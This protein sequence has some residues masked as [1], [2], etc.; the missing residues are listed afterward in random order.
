M[1]KYGA[2]LLLFLSLPAPPYRIKAMITEISRQHALELFAPY[3][4]L[5]NKLN[6][7]KSDY[8]CIDVC[9]KQA[10]KSR[11]Q[12]NLFHS[13]LQCFWESG[14]SSFNDYE[15]IGIVSPTGVFLPCESNLI[16]G[17]DEELNEKCE[18]FLNKIEEDESFIKFW[19]NVYGELANKNAIV[20]GICVCD[21]D[22][23][24]KY[25]GNIVFDE[26]KQKICFY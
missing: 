5:V 18:M 15:L 26:E 22:D 13:L 4:G 14:C 6:K 16:L 8:V 9:S 24:N 2:V 12:N 7:M 19:K 3:K 21:E 20:S 23:D 10:L 11:E 17:E 1:V 25:L